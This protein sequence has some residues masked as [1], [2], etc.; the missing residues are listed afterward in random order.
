[1]NTEKLIEKGVK[2]HFN[3]KVV[4]FSFESL[5][6]HYDGLKV[7]ES[8]I[9]KVLDND[10]EIDYYKAE[11]I[12]FDEAVEKEI[13]TPYDESEEGTVGIASRLTPEEANEII[14]KVNE[15]I[16]VSKPKKSKKSKK[17]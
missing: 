14:T 6:E 8:D 1:M 10:K 15:D 9:V 12:S 16:I 7:H 2:K 13:K 5:K 3:G 11:D 4:L 17:Q